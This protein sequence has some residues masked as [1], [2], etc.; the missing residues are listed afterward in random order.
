MALQEVSSGSCEGE[1]VGG[2][3]VKVGSKRYAA[4]RKKT[5]VCIS[6]LLILL[7]PPAS[8]PDPRS[9]RR[10][11]CRDEEAEVEWEGLGGPRGSREGL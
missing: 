9:R 4:A 7:R 8:R 2:E 5:G 10:V 6:S 3:E 1:E 11:E